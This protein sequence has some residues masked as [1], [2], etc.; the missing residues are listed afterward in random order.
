M[1][2]AI[3]GKIVSINDTEEAIFRSGEISFDG[4]M[5]EVNLAAVPDARVGDYVLIHV[6]MAIT[7]VDEDEAKKSLALFRQMEG[8]SPEGL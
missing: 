8:E 7:V 3:P 6:G 1:C 5:R 4:V 2:L